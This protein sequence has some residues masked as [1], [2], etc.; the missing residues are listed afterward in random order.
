L[1]VWSARLDRDPVYS[2]VHREAVDEHNR[3]LAEPP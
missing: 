1:S 2:C 3:I